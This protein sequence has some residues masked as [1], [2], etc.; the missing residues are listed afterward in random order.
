MVTKRFWIYVGITV[1]VVSFIATA[2]LIMSQIKLIRYKF[3]GLRPKSKFDASIK[4]K[5]QISLNDERLSSDA[6]SYPAAAWLNT[7]DRRK[8][9]TPSEG[10]QLFDSPNSRPS[11]T[12][13][14]RRFSA[15]SIAEDL[16][17]EDLKLQLHDVTNNIEQIGVKLERTVAFNMNIEDQYLEGN[18]DITKF[19]VKLNKKYE[20][21][22]D[23]MSDKEELQLQEMHTRKKNLKQSLS[24]GND[25]E[26]QLRNEIE[27]NY[28]TLHRLKKHPL[29]QNIDDMPI[30]TVLEN[31]NTL[32]RKNSLNKKIT[33]TNKEKDEF[34]NTDN[35][36]GKEDVAANSVRTEDA[37]STNSRKAG[38][39]DKDEV[40]NTENLAGKE[41]IADSSVQTEDTKSTN[42]R[43]SGDFD[44]SET[45][46][47][48]L[49]NDDGNSNIED[50]VDNKLDEK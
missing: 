37:I 1:A 12:L 35:L 10:S 33:P 38:D 20:K 15:H 42:S 18:L 4:D 21:T 17:F 32:E 14:R 45:K 3:A 39:K 23:W 5:V 8:S 22:H 26:Q 47:K 6:E 40:E 48:S 13:S 2:I 46:R 43:K 11:S 19:K 34:E 30:K 7:I 49:H 28:V 9:L 25:I 16:S 44:N 36:A 31:G 27:Q 24:M 50:S 41:E 29:I